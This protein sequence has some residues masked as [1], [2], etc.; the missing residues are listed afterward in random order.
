MILSSGNVSLGS[1]GLDHL[2]FFGEWQVG[3]SRRGV[4]PDRGVWHV[5]LRS[6][7]SF[8]RAASRGRH[9]SVSAWIEMPAGE[10]TSVPRAASSGHRPRRSFCCCG[11]PRPYAISRPA[12]VS[13]RRRCR[14]VECASCRAWP[15]PHERRPR[16]SAVDGPAVPLRL[17]VDHAADVSGGGGSDHRLHRLAG[18]C[19]LARQ[20]RARLLGGGRLSAGRHHRRSRL[21]AAARRLWRAGA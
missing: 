21:R 1:E 9:V 5:V 2:P 6:C 18:D 15:R 4:A 17:S 3:I 14:R 8:A 7:R 19:R 13:W 16:T 12:A 11:V 10:T 20:R